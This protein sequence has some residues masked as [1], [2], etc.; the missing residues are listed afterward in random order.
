[1]G[2]CLCLSVQCMCG[3]HEH[4]GARKVQS[5]IV[6]ALLNMNDKHPRSELQSLLQRFDS[7]EGGGVPQELS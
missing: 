7:L 3:K 6:E 2:F 5:T 1:M 4:T